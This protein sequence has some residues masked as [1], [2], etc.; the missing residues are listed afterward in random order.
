MLATLLWKFNI[1]PAPAVDQ[2]P[3]RPRHHQFE[4]GNDEDEAFPPFNL[5]AKTLCNCIQLPT[6]PTCLVNNL[7]IHRYN[8]S[9]QAGEEEKELQEA[10]R[11]SNSLA[12]SDRG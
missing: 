11:Y 5:H 2:C 7:T 4:D 12:L 9:A 10:G 6:N 1:L 8:N 3:V